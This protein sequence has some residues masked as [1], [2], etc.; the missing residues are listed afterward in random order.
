M[1]LRERVIFDEASSLSNSRC[2]TDTTMTKEERDPTGDDE[3]KNVDNDSLRTESEAL[4]SEGCNDNIQTEKRIWT[5]IFEV[6]IQRRGIFWALSYA[7]LTSFAALTIKLLSGKVSP[8]QI[9]LYR[10]LTIVLFTAPNLQR[11]RVSFSLPL[12]AWSLVVFRGIAGMAMAISYY[13][14]IQH[15]DISTAK[16]IRQ[17]STFITCILACVCLKEDCSIAI[18]LS[19]CISVVGVFLV[20][21][22]API[23]EGLLES[24]SDHSPLG[25]L[26]A[27]S[28]ALCMSLIYISL[29]FLAPFKVNAQLIN[30]AYGCIGFLGSALLETA[31]NDWSIPRCGYDRQILLATCI[32]GYFQVIIITI[33]LQT[34]NAAVVAVIS[35]TAVF[36]T[37]VLDYAFYDVTPNAFKI[38]GGLCVTGSSV[39]ATM[40]SYYAAKRRLSENRS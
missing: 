8:N 16:C 2:L 7:I 27:F 38:I 23:F 31:L 6:M 11:Q 20:V 39:G 3:Q 15:L 33:A 24:N 22:P 26:A 37:F 21:Q 17:G 28:A 25:L 29:R 35:T 12:K 13:Y 9:M 36:G 19:C 4:V 10:S 5:R 40:S 32:I 34:E 30:L 18:S 14:A 1:E